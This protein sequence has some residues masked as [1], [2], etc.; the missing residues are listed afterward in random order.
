MAASW[1]Q[2]PESDA[3][4]QPLQHQSRQGGSMSKSKWQCP[5][6]SQNARFKRHFW[7]CQGSRLLGSSILV[8]SARKDKEWFMK[9]CTHPI[10]MHLELDSLDHWT[11]CTQAGRV[12]DLKVWV[13]KLVT[14]PIFTSSWSLSPPGYMCLTY[15]EDRLMLP[16]VNLWSE[17]AENQ[18]GRKTVWCANDFSSP[19]GSES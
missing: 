16:V 15:F 6:C 5:G 14:I 9:I 19:Y 1:L 17:W 10:E 11:S 13:F 7:I 8:I 3:E 4:S 18:G 12:W 2:L